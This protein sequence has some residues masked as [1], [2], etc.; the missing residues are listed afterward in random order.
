MNVRSKK[1]EEALKEFFSG[2]LNNQKQFVDSFFDHPLIR[3]LSMGSGGRPPYISPETVGQVV[4][5]LVTANG[6]VT[7]L[8]DAVDKLPG[9]TE[10]NR[11]KG[12]LTTLV[13][14]TSGDA[15]LFRKAVET[16]FDEVM[17]RASGWFKRHQQIVAL[18]VSTVFIVSANVDTFTL[19]TSLSSSSELRAKMVLNAEQLSKEKQQTP[20]GVPKA[21]QDKAKPVDRK[22]EVASDAPTKAPVDRKL[23]LD[24]AIKAYDQARVALETGGLQFGWKD[25]PSGKG[26]QEWLTKIFGL[27]ISIF[28]VSLG[29]PFWFDLL[30][31]FMQVRQAGISPRE[32][33]A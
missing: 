14:Q 15:T 28:A 2:N 20:A 8:R 32:K 22:P 3:T 25:C 31:R 4:Q 10:D 18:V 9:S 6:A 30:Q 19:A 17:D 13:V 12:L 16:H 26:W 29:A 24:E 11:I 33:K 1:L 21:E 5:S 7:S 27:L 23:K